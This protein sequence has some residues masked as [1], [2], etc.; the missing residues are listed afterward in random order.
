M[1]T[2]FSTLERWRRRF[3]AEPEYLRGLGGSLYTVEEAEPLWLER[4]QGNLDTNVRPQPHPAGLA[5]G[6]EAPPAPAVA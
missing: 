1:L 5:P 6:R 3:A 2:E 4:K